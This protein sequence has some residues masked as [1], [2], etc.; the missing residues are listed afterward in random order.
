MMTER[1][2]FLA[3]CGVGE[4]GQGKSVMQVAT[5]F[6]NIADDTEEIVRQLTMDGAVVNIFRSMRFT[7]VD[8]KFGSGTDYDFIQTVQLLSEFTTAENSID[9]NAERIP[10][11][12]L[13]L[14]PK[15]LEGEYYVCGIHG[16]WCVMPSEAGRMPDMVRFMF[17]NDCLHTYRIN[18]DAID[19]DLIEEAVAR[20]IEFG[21]SVDEV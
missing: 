3:S 1:D 17:D 4:E 15:Q 21:T 9:D 16:T 18:E 20:N 7:M 13:T 14:M 6:L 2:V 19:E 10:C 5:K 12:Q 11:V 8:L